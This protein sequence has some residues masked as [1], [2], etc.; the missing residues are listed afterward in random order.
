MLYTSAMNVLTEG[1]RCYSA[2]PAEAVATGTT[3]GPPMDARGTLSTPAP[4][5]VTFSTNEVR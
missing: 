1:A 2:I 4:P 3:M 5:C